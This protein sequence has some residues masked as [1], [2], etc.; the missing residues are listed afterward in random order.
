MAHGQKYGT[1]S[2]YQT[3]YSVVIEQLLRFAYNYND[4]K[5]ISLLSTVLVNIPKHCSEF[6]NYTVN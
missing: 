3:H 1:P 2:E 4:W 6:Y 5:W